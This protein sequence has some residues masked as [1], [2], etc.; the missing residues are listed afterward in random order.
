VKPATVHRIVNASADA[1]ALRAKA[2]RETHGETAL[3]L[4]VEALE[5][6]V[7]ALSEA[8]LEGTSADPSKVK[9]RK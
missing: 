7:E 8:M 2:A 4:R 9:A 3:R 5:A 1:M 6:V